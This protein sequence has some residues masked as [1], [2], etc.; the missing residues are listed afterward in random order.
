M[1][2]KGKHNTQGFWFVDN[3]F[4]LIGI[5][6]SLQKLSLPSG[7]YA[8]YMYNDTN[9]SL[10]NLLVLCGKYS[11]VLDRL[12]QRLDLTQKTHA[13]FWISK[14]LAYIQIQD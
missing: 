11:V 2:F 5:Y 12:P 9:Q 3:I 1:L 7:D 13:D 10:N 14:T 4:L 8:N 6:F